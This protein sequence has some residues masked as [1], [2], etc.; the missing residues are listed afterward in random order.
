MYN[1]ITKIEKATNKNP[2]LNKK[3][4]LNISVKNIIFVIF[5]YFLIIYLYKYTTWALEEIHFKNII[6]WS[7]EY[8]AYI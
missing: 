3:S 6:T 1:Y 2:F 4:K 7:T 8:C 5:F